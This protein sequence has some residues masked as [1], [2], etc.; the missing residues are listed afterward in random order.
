MKENIRFSVV[1]GRF[2]WW[3]KLDISIPNGWNLLVHSNPSYIDS[4]GES[5][6]S[7][8]GTIDN[9][10]LKGADCARLVRAK[11]ATFDNQSFA[12]YL[13]DVA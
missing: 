13:L 3:E 12:R 2:Y 4:M 6:A 7:I 10:T 9:R 8:A 5:T 1:G 11:P